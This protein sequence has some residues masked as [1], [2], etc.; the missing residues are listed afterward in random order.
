MRCG[1]VLTLRLLLAL[2]TDGWTGFD[3]AVGMARDTLGGVTRWLEIAAVAALYVGAAKIGLTLS[4]AYSNVTP[5]W[6]PTGISLAALLLFGYRVWPG[7]AIGAF[8]ANVTT[9][10]P[11]WV[12]A[13]IG[14]GNTLEA[15]VGAYLLRRVGFR[16]E[17]DRVRNVLALLLFGAAVSTCISATIGT[18]ALWLGDEI[19]GARYGFAWR[20]WWFGDAMGALLVAPLFL[21]WGSGPLR[22]HVRARELIEEVAI[23]GLLVG[24]SWIV[25]VGGRWRYPYLLFPL[26][27]WCALRFRPRGASLAIF[28]I[29]AIGVIGTL[30]GSVPIGGATLTDSVQIL[31]V[32]MGL[33]AVSTLVLAAT[34]TERESAE[35]QAAASLSLLRGTL[36]STTDGILVVDRQGK[37]L[38]SNQRFADMWRIPQDVIEARDDHRLIAFVLDQ[39]IDPEGFSSKIRELYEQPES[40]SYDQLVFKD[41]RV[42]ERYSQPQRIGGEIAGRVWSFRDVTEKRATEKR[43]QRETALREEFI[44]NAAHEL[45]TPVTTLF[46][47]SK[48]L[49][50]RA[51]TMP[52]ERVNQS[53]D[54]MSRQGDRLR[55]LV[56]NLLD[57][58]ALQEARLRVD[59]QP[60]LLSEVVSRTLES[61]P[62][63]DGK[64]VEADIDASLVVLADPHRLE[65]IVTNLI[66]N[67]YRYGGTSIRVDASTSSNHV[68]ISVLDD[69]TGVP[70]ELVPRLFDAFTRGE[71]SRV[72]TGSGLGLA[73]VKRLAEATGA[74]IW[75]E[76]GPDRGAC[77][78]LRLPRVDQW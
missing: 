21:T 51:H 41:G 20:L 72:V 52:K 32:L 53:L 60:I 69:G 26:L 35:R 73:I 31:Q 75:Y 61:L 55:T 18:T 10:I 57:L 29:A 38:T 71:N 58:S 56:N 27:V 59:P 15:L 30:E 23:F 65:Q 78:M 37:V 62:P 13:S 48:L 64:V 66:T 67:A 45:R 1:P 19:P 16:A 39:L 12:A 36:E 25:F 76:P 50:E 47:L 14:V 3:A 7:V 63:P 70:E 24:A 40:E 44:A 8:V 2:G 34:I 74:E 42:F 43:L 9:P 6:A 17:L 49:H 33:L 5:V 4:V 46:G 54:A 11:V 22:I 68:V 77:F 28:I